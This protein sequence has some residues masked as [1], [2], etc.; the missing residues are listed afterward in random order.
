[1]RATLLLGVL[2]V[3]SAQAEVLHTCTTGDGVNVRVTL[4]GERDRATRMSVSPL[5]TFQPPQPWSGEV[6]REDD[7]DFETSYRARAT[8]PR[9]R[10]SKVRANHGRGYSA[11]LT[12]YSESPITLT[13][14]DPK[15]L[16]QDPKS[17][18]DLV[19]NLGEGYLCNVTTTNDHHVSNFV[20]ERSKIF[21]VKAGNY[22]RVIRDVVRNGKTENILNVRASL[23]RI[24]GGKLEYGWTRA[25]DS[26]HQELVLTPSFAT[27]HEV[28]RLRADGYAGD[29]ERQEKLFRNI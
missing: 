17:S 24:S 6:V 27:G 1:M 23:R 16:F 28:I 18:A 29:C 8:G 20:A 25:Y 9:I 21:I 22:G 5:G 12:G 2:L 7:S 4:E 19:G 15:S 13:C 11:S 14:D 10:F 3:S 26:V